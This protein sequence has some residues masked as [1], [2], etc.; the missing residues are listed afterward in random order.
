MNEK[1]QFSKNS[2]LKKI[3][4]S[5]VTNQLPNYKPVPS[6]RLPCSL[7]CFSVQQQEMLTK[8]SINSQLEEAIFTIKLFDELSQE[9]SFEKII[10][11]IEQ[12]K[13]HIVD[14][15]AVIRAN[16]NNDYSSHIDKGEIVIKLTCLFE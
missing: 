15:V 2:Y 3:I 9:Q 11:N 14:D 6:K 5:Y 1:P 4:S 13:D 10:D 12:L 16:A 8:V 7:P